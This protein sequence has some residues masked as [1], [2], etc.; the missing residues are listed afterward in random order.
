MN[1]TSGAVSKRFSRLKAKLEVSDQATTA[2]EE[3][4]GTS[5]ALSPQK[6]TKRKRNAS[7]P[8]EESDAYS[9]GERSEEQ[10]KPAPKAKKTRKTRPAWTVNVSQDKDDMPLASDSA[11]RQLQHE[12]QS[13]VEFG[14]SQRSETLTNTAESQGFSHHTVASIDPEFSASTFDLPSDVAHILREPV[15]P[16]QPGLA[17]PVADRDGSFESKMPATPLSRR[18]EYRNLLD[19][20]EATSRPGSMTPSPRRSHSPYS[21]SSPHLDSQTS[22]IDHTPAYKTTT[23]ESFPRLD[24]EETIWQ[25]MPYP[26]NPV[27]SM[28]SYSQNFFDHRAAYQDLAGGKYMYDEENMYGE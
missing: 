25:A 28:S 6:A 8:D 20:F 26:L 11:G 18:S 22:R 3:E 23:G 14:P 4:P 12:M 16:I 17:I 5:P 19:L 24:A 10:K 2:G 21:L 13:T 1:T 15:G 9:A 7:S 27:S